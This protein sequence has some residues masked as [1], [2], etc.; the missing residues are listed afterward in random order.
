MDDHLT[1]QRFNPHV[2]VH[3]LSGV[4]ACYQNIFAEQPW[5]EWKKC[6]VCNK[7]WGS[8]DSEEIIS[9]NSIHCDQS[10]VDFWPEEIVVIDLL[11]EI[12]QE[13]SSWI[14]LD[15]EKVVGFCW[16]YPISPEDLEIKL[17]LP[18]LANNIKTYSEDCDKVAYQDE[19]GLLSEYRNK[20]IA[21]NLVKARLNDFRDQS[22]N[23]GVL[24]TKTNPP[25][26]TYLWY[27]KLGYQVI[28]E[29][30]DDDQRVILANSFD[31]LHLY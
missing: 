5:N 20:G 19:L 22:L 2:D 14:V 8:D 25:T 7:K 27:Q 6:V 31:C 17:E 10:L 9:L 11:K 12:N 1:Y 21:K 29:Y 18:G 24:R 4:V 23:V 15:Q 28:A 13:A 3:F 26:V 30:N 16:G